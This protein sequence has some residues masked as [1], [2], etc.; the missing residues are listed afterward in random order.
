MSDFRSN[1]F[2]F[3][4]T[5][6]LEDHTQQIDEDDRDFRFVLESLSTLTESDDDDDVPVADHFIKMVN[7]DDFKAANSK[8]ETKKLNVQTYDEPHSVQACPDYSR[9]PNKTDSP[10]SRTSKKCK[11]QENFPVKLFQIL[12][13]SDIGEY[14][15]IISWL[16]HGRAFKIHDEDLFQERI[17]K[18]YFQQSKLES[19]KRQLYVYGFRKIGK[20][21]ADIGAYYHE[22]FIRGRFDL[23]G[24]ITR[25]N[26]KESK[27]NIRLPSYCNMPQIMPTN[28]NMQLGGYV[29]Q[30]DCCSEPRIV[31][32]VVLA[33]EK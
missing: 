13:R 20:R 17:M 32:Y 6:L 1:P 31:Q 7:T 27:L 22:L 33:D 3:E 10:K 18:K 14:S 15:S 28:D 12:E 26:G 29:D 2:E 11:P 9:L 25:W 8:R 30:S 16:P 4:A 23:T 5:R 24:K 21:F 19:F